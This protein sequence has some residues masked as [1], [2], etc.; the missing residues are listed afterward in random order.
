MIRPLKK[1]ATATVVIKGLAIAKYN[2]EQ[3]KWE[4]TFL[5]D[6]GHYPNIRIR[7]LNRESG[8]LVASLRSYEIQEG[9]SISITVTA[10]HGDN[11]RRYVNGGIFRRD[12]ASHDE[13]DLRWMM[14]IDQLHGKKT[15]RKANPIATN[16][17]SIS[18]GCFYTASRTKKTYRIK[19]IGSNAPQPFGLTGRSFGVDFQAAA[20]TIQVQGNDGFTQTLEEKPDR[21]YEII[22]DNTCF[23][24][25]QPSPGTTD[26][27]HYYKL[28]D[29]ND[30]K[31]D[32]L[33][34]EEPDVVAF[35]EDLPEEEDPEPEGDPSKTPACHSITEGEPVATG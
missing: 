35:Q 34:P 26:F 10:P 20:L 21:R 8:R 32:I 13:Q 22:F 30:G 16:L 14:D 1:E 3:S 25:G 9:D 7:Q 19:K 11:P 4:V 23:D 28:I 6:C 2:H 12:N 33:S 29:D 5:R 31:V 27:Q 15:K 24:G 18:N 17:L